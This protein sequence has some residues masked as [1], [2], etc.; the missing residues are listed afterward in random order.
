MKKTLTHLTGI[1]FLIAIVIIG[2]CN[3]TVMNDEE[4]KS[5]DDLID[6]LLLASKK[7]TIT[8]KAEKA[9]DGS[10]QFTMWDK[11]DME[12]AKL[13]SEDPLKFDNHLITDV[14][15]SI[16]VQWRWAKSSEVKEFVEIGPSAPPGKI[17]PG[18]AEPQTPAR[19]V[20][21]IVTLNTAE[22]NDEDRYYIK[23]LW[24]E[25]TVTIDPHLKVPPG[26]PPN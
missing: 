11:D 13:V 12:V 15:T 24:N 18:K 19:K 3:T 7:N 10:L 20:L 21:T 14:D 4:E 17:F 26:V 25:D 9:E 23:F 5:K 1:V 8:C 16:V 6:S 22:K 2:S